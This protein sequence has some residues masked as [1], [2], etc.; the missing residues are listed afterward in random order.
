MSREMDGEAPESRF[1]RLLA[2]GQ[3]HALVLALLL[4]TAQVLADYLFLRLPPALVA[5]HPGQPT[6]FHHYLVT[7]GAYSDLYTLYWQHKLYNHPVPY[8]DIRIQY[9]VLLGMYMTAAAAV[10][11]SVGSYFV[12]SGLGLWASA[13]TCVCC[14]WS[15]SRRAALLFAA[16]PILLVF[17]LLNW[18]LFAIALMLL[19]WRA[20]QR[21]RPVVAA[22]WFT[23]GT[24]AKLY[25]GLLLFFCGVELVR[26]WRKGERPGRA[27]V[28]Y[29]GTAVVA[30]G[31][32]NL[33]FMVMAYHRW[34]YFFLFNKD[35]NA[36]MSIVDWLHIVTSST[37]P[38][39]ANGI[40][41][42]ALAAT[43]GLGAVAL[44]RGAS[45]ER[46]AASAF[47]I[48]LMMQK[49]YSPQYALWLVA[50]ALVAG[51]ETWTIALANMLGFANYSSAAVTNYLM[52]TSDRVATWY[53][54]HVQPFQRDVRLTVLTVVV[55]GSSLAVRRRLRTTAVPEADPG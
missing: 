18:D 30:A 27:V 34:R 32:I 17:S 8:L 6:V 19:G 37:S 16:S 22:L 21:D 46:V 35:R 5:A 42:A 38:Q 49:T 13:V 48:V 51:W 29:A 45:V 31:V 23:L 41:E 54:A 10:T 36:H 2:W 14:L 11:H 24:F 7:R 55:V 20:W 47:V 12:V 3:R 40:V 4:V 28:A 15:V 26:R 39:L 53:S 9:P 43:L 50:F 1:A 25:P 44:W 33:P 52:H